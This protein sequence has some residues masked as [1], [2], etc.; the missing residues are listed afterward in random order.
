[1]G[2]RGRGGYRS[3]S[4]QR[5]RLRAHAIFSLYCWRRS[6]PDGAA[7]P[8]DVLERVVC[9]PARLLVRTHAAGQRRAVARA[10]N[11]TW[12]VELYLPDA[13]AESALLPWRTL[14]TGAIH[15]LLMLAVLTFHFGGLPS[16]F[17]PPDPRVD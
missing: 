14:C 1:M 3:L 2:A 5:V 17:L 15:R 4:S 13:V 11:R 10:T 9:A 16:V 12:G 6:V 7:V 8:G